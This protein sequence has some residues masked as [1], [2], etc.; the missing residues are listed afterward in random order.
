MIE[1][2]MVGRMIKRGLL[3]APVV[4]LVLGLIGGTEWALSGA[5]G[6][7]MTLANLW[8]AARIIGGVAENRPELLLAAAMAAFILG[9]GALTVVA[10]ALRGIE[11]VSWPVA[12]LTLIAAHFVLVTFEAARNLPRSTDV[13]SRDAAQIRS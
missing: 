9:L 8:L 11:A 3:M 7:A 5:I 1:L 13:S 10:I 12:G 2:A 6:L 4:V